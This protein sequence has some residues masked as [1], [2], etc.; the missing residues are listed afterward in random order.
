MT[1]KRE[2]VVQE[3]RV[4]TAI[5]GP[6]SQEL[7]ERRNAVLST[8]IGT[9]LPAFIER[10]EGAILVDVDGNQIVDMGSGIGVVT[11]GHGNE[12]V[13]E[14]AKKQ[15]DDFTH[16]LITVSPYEEY[17]RVAE[18]L[19]KHSPVPGPTKSLLIN[20]GAEA[21][22]NAVKISRKYTGKNGV[23][24][25]ECAYHGRTMLTSSMTHKAV[26]YSAGFGPRAGDI[27]RVPNS[28]PLH[29][30]L[31]GEEAA[32]RT[33]KYIEKAITAGDLACLIAEPIQGEGGFT[34]PADGYLPALAK[35]CRENNVVF[36]AD[37]VQSGIARTGTVYASEQFGL[38]PDIVL[39]AK[40][41]AGGLPISAVTGRQEI[42]DCT[43]PGSLGGTYSGNPVAC[44]A[45]ISVFEQIEAGG[46][47]E[48]AKRIEEKLGGGLRKLQEKHPS[49]AEVRGKGAMLA[50]E[51]TE[52]G[53][54][55]PAADVVTKVIAEAGQKGVLLLNAG[56]SGNIIRFLPPLTLSNELIEDVLNVLDEAL[57]AATA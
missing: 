18:Y 49:I 6:K 5:P 51:L 1:E 54:L 17:V 24:V 15:L 50:I 32:A 46:V 28:Y 38:E 21:V 31:S 41:I 37:E 43:G 53:T 19:S 47:L 33:I 25:L 56:L 29:D 12:G 23:A 3:R 34:V 2:P 40:G 35:W 7:M 13:R 8:G 30:G 11:I 42:M 14:A 16:T 10:A 9:A 26:P 36:I 22:E 55:K 4:V 57:T 45:A 27:H 48:D 39:T 44:A 52:P 20:S